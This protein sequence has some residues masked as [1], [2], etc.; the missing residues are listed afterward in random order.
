TE[1]DPALT[2]I[3][4]DAGLVLSQTSDNGYRGTMVA[5]VIDIEGDFDITVTYDQFQTQTQLDKIS[6]V[7]LH[8]ETDTKNKDLALI[9]N[10]ENRSNERIVQCLR[11]SV[12]DGE[13]RRS[14][15]GPQ[16][17][18]GDS[19]KMRLSRRGNH[20]Y[21]LAAD[22]DSDSFRLVG[23]DTFPTDTLVSRGV[24]LGVQTQGPGGNV[25]ARFLDMSIR[26][27]RLG[28]MTTVDSDAALASLDRQREQLPATF[29]LDFSKDLRGS[30]E[31][32]LWGDSHAT[33]SGL[34]ILSTGDDS[35][36][37]AGVAL[38]RGIVGDFDIHFD[39]KPIAMATP[40][41]GKHTQVYLQLEL[42][43]DEQ[44]QLNVILTKS[45]NGSLTS[46]AQTRTR[47]N[48]SDKYQVTATQNIGDPDYFR[49]A[50]KQSKIYL[51]VGRD[52]DAKEFLLD[53][54]NSTNAPISPRSVRMML[55]TGGSGRQSEMLIRSIQ[56][57]ADATSEPASPILEIRQTNPPLQRVPVKPPTPQR[58]ILD[59]LKSLFQ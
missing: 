40:A 41:K 31:F 11:M 53:T 35:W 58:S 2:S 52:S 6:C 39:F 33:D 9:Q 48:G 7:R 56:I 1:G 46:Q 47:P 18:D 4:T 51:I 30:D 36:T 54:F 8:V 32:Y 27:E 17:H 5:P 49:I 34:K 16:P 14:Y 38:Q 24:R 10:V 22:N 25:S 29:D 21:Y 45:N 59:S 55:H 37:S 50:R 13:D 57:K 43:D 3:A 28:G 23:E 26:A 12:V 19:G 15:F 42:S 20:I 44:T